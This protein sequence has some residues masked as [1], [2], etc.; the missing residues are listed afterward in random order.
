MK[1]AVLYIRENTEDIINAWEQKVNEEIDVSRATSSLILRNQ[2]S[3]V[4]KDIADVMDRYDDFE[5][6]NQNEDFEEILPNSLDHGRHRASSSHY[7]V[8]QVLLEYLIFHRVLTNILQEQDAYTTEVG[9]LLNFTVQ[10]AMINSATSFTQSLQEMREKLIGTLAHDIRNPLSAIYLAVDMLKYENGPEK[11]EK[12]KNLIHQWNMDSSRTRKTPLGFTLT[13]GEEEES[14][15][16]KPYQVLVGTLLYL[17]TTTRPDLCQAASQLSRFMADPKNSHWEAAKNVLKYLKETVNYGLCLGNRIDVLQ[18]ELD[19]DIDTF[20]LS[21]Y[22]DADYATDKVTRKSRTRY[23]FVLSGSLISRQSKLQATVSTSTAE[24]EYQAASSA[25][26]EGLWLENLL[27]DFTSG[28]VKQQIKMF[29]DNQACI[30]IAQSSGSMV[31]T[32]HIDV[33][34]HFVRERVLFGEVNF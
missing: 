5:K 2:L 16:T 17:S 9:I 14:C 34:H 32:K 22:S 3:Y 12:V 20:T 1:K 21:G 7:A 6:V 30:K 26:K 13:K 23:V 33:A 28:A 8:K 27:T 11:I 4:L 10:T 18:K 31:R 19:Q 24:A 29:C 15:Q 25:V